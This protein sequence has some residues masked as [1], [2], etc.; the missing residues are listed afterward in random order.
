MQKI[1]VNNDTG[2]PL[3][4]WV[5]PL[6]EDYWLNPGERFTVSSDTELADPATVAP[7]EVTVHAQ[8]VSVFSNVGHLAGVH[9]ASGTEV[10]CG[11]Q[12]PTE[13]P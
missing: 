7:F 3:T 12:R 11:H 8:G 13:A 5:E 10:H 6:G 2:A 4:L 1:T 9:D